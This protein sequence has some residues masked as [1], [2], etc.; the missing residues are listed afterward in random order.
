FNFNNQAELICEFRIQRPGPYQYYVSYKT[1]ADIDDGSAD[2][3]DDVIAAAG[4]DATTVIPA[5]ER[6]YR[7]FKE[8]R[9]PVSYF[10]VDPQLML[11]GQYLPLDGIVLQSVNPKW[12]GPMNAWSPHFASSHKTGYNMIHFIPMQQRGGSNSPYSLYNQLELSDD[13]FDGDLTAAEKNARLRE[14]LLEM[15]H[16]HRLLGITDMVW[17]HTAFN[18]DWLASH[19]EAGFNLENSPHLRSA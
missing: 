11:A 13:L 5:V 3:C 12:M 1:L 17:N 2:V 9:T 18:S 14:T 15:T 7:D 8:H 10:L 4:A 6:I 16:K 19:P